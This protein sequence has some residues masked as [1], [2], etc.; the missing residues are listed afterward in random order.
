MQKFIILFH[1]IQSTDNSP[2]KARTLFELCSKAS[3]YVQTLLPRRPVF[4]PHDQTCKSVISW[5][6]HVCLFVKP[7][8]L[9]EPTAE[10]II[11]AALLLVD[12]NLRNQH[13]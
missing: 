10:L 11:Q 7:V 4:T 1:Y 13:K 9:V 6:R 8:S 3:K 12:S 2:Q 5:C